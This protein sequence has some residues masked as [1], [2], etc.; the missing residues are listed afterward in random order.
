[1]KKH[2]L[3]LKAFALIILFALAFHSCSD[4]DNPKSFLD[5]HGG[6]VWKFGD[7]NDILSLY[8][9]INNSETNPFEFWLYDLID[10]CYLHESVTNEGTT[11]VL[12]NSENK[13]EIKISESS[14]DY[15]ILTMT[16]SGDILRV[17]FD[18]YEDGELTE[19]E[20]FILERSNDNV[21]DL[22]ICETL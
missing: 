21:D 22:T 15:G 1:M 8:A 16:V 11:E 19:D 17:Q 4:D 2:I 20:Q 18:S 9:Q 12:Q 6:T 14:G 3:K 7:A 13:I 10:E 5:A